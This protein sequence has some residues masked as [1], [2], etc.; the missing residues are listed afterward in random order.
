MSPELISADYPFES[1]YIEVQGA[2]MHYLDEGQ[3]RPVLFLHGNPTWSYLWRNVIPRVSGA[4]RC[5]APDLIGMG[6]SD[7][8]DLEYTF[9][10][11]YRF[12]EGFIRALDLRD[13][14]LVIHD[15]GSAL[16]FHFASQNED[17]IAGLAFMEAIVAPVPS[18]DDFHPDFQA[19]FKD[20]RTPPKGWDLIVNQNFFVEQ[21]LPGAI[22]RKLGQAEMDAYREPYRKPASRK[23]LWAWPNQIP[24]AG[25]P[26]E[27][28]AA[29]EAYNRWLVQTP[30]PKLLFYASPG[31]LIRKA[32]VAWCRQNLSNL[33]TVDLGAGIHFV[34]EDHPTLIGDELA[35]WLKGLA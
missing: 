25:E 2:R 13:L 8:P 5:L 14:V 28:V 18:W 15:W 4:A 29:V 33:K 24:I 22:V 11:H 17:R 21:V 19:M 10:D 27:V 1:H 26:P 30:L 23:P 3:G 20:F 9:F 34:Q 12:V 35:A 32:Q 16:G 31:A 7:K 6:R